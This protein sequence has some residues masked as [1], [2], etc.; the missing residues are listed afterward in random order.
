MKNVLLIPGVVLS[1]ATFHANI[2]YIT[3]SAKILEKYIKI[4]PLNHR[5]QRHSIT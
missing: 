2:K 1:I 4:K 5:L 3:I